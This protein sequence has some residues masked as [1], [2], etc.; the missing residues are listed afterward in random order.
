LLFLIPF[1]IEN[2]SSSIHIH[3]PIL[4]QQQGRPKSKRYRKGDYQRKHKKCSIYSEKGHD[5]RTC[6]N[7]PVAN[8]RRQQAR[9]RAFLSSSDS[10]SD[11]Q[12][13]EIIEEGDSTDEDLQAQLEQDLQF[14][15]EMRAFEQRLEQHD[16][17]QASEHAKAIEQVEAEEWAAAARGV[18]QGPIESDVGEDGSGGESSGL[19]TVSS[20]RF[21]ELDEDWWKGNSDSEVVI[22]RLQ[23]Q[24]N[25]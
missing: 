6:R 14:R 10:S 16:V 8:G 22:V 13:N 20:S 17:W 5:K 1:S 25:A 24:G 12:Q 11:V 9:D 19:S 23:S 15:Q 4:Q 21:E 7:Q 3:P 2:L 18:S